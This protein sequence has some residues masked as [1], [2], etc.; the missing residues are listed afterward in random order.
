[1]PETYRSQHASTIADLMRQRGQIE[2]QRARSIGDATAAARM[3]S[4]QAWGGAI[5]NITQGVSGTLAD[6]ARQRA[7]APRRAMEDEL[8]DLRLKVARGELDQQRIAQMG[9]EIEG[10]ATRPD[11]SV[12]RDLLT[13]LFQQNGIGALLPPV[14]RELDKQEQVQRKE[15]EAT[16]LRSFTA[17]PPGPISEDA[18]GVMNEAPEAQPF[19]R[20]AFG[21]GTAEGPERMETAPE[22]RMRETEAFAGQQ[23]GVVSPAGAITLPPRPEKPPSVS[24]RPEDVFLDG[25][26]AKA[27][28]NPSTGVFTVGGQDVTDRVRPIPPR[29]PQPPA[30]RFSP[31]EVTINGQSVT[32]NYD[33]QTG[34][35]HHVDTGEVL[36]G[37]QA[38]PT[39]DM[40]NKVEGR[41]L[42]KKSIGAIETLSRT[43]ITKV[44][45][46][47]RAQAIQRGAEAVFGNDPEF[48]TY[49]DARMALAGNL[50]VAQQGSRPSDAD[51]KAV[52]LPLVP[53]PYRD[54]SESNEM[55][56]RLIKDMSNVAD[57]GGGIV[58]WEVGPDG[59][60][61]PKGG[62]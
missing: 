62:G 22:R 45:P 5:Q 2:G 30:Q 24:L 52:W 56:W 53:D 12:D 39:A 4:G 18:L 11:G 28:F 55:K 14:L 25:R 58:E 19:L 9:A 38:A 46:A 42:V 33:A 47:Q 40:R 34:K 43:I 3:A 57:D 32:A 50:A 36:A 54:T 27:I 60:Y 10:Q 6:F 20:Y 8:A 51:I 59:R 61:R 26:P 48:R 17:T 49:Q 13:S 35:Y 16:G 15:R 21:P 1:M 41:K 31:R 37:V 7:D 44:G 23:G 29:D